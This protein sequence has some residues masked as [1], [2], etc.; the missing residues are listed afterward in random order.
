[1]LELMT[2]MEMYD[3]MMDTAKL[4][5]QFGIKQT[6]LEEAVLS[7]LSKQRLSQSLRAA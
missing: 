3:S 6:T 7:Y 5:K 4:S 2:E 1:M